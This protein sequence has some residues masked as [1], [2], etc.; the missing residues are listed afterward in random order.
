MYL[1]YSEYKDLGG[2]KVSESDFTRL[3][4]RAEKTID[5]F[6]FGRLKAMKSTPEEVKRLMVEL[7]DME[8][9]T[10]AVRSG[11]AVVKS[12]STDGYSESYET[13]DMDDLEDIQ[14]DLIYEYL[15]DVLD[16]NGV[17]LLYKGVDA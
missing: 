1:E 17:P 3:A 2:T 8:Y 7:V 4:Y 11:E 14:Q 16:D 13:A 9:N 10:Q 5:T 6:T 12:F 15:I